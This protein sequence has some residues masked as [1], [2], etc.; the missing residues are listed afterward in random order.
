LQLLSMRELQRRNPYVR[1]LVADSVGGEIRLAFLEPLRTIFGGGMGTALVKSDFH[2][3]WDP[4]YS[5]ASGAG[6]RLTDRVGLT[7]QVPSF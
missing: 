7:C 4:T 6:V 3:D 1:F 2:T 5:V